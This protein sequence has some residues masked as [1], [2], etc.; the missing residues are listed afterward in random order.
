MAQQ[1]GNVHRVGVLRVGPTPPSW[2]E[3]FRK[4]LRD[5]GYVE[6][7]NLIIEF[8]LAKTAS[9]LPELSAELIQ[10]KVDVI[11]ASGTPSV[12]PAKHSGIPVV[13]VA[14]VDPVAAGVAASLAKPGGNVTG[15]SA[16]HADVTGKRLQL[17]K[18]LI[19]KI[20]KIA[21]LVRATSP[22]APQYV[23]E[24][25]DAAGILSVE[26]QVLGVRDPSQFEVAFGS[27]QA[28]GALIVSDDAVFTAER[29]RIAELAVKNRLPTIYGFGDMVEA[30]GLMAYGPHY[31]DLYRRAAT[32]VH[33]ILTGTKPADIAIE[34]PTKFEMV[35]N[36]KTAKALGLE[37]PPAFLAR[38]DQV[39]E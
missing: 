12:M 22:A 25:Q 14:A 4:G 1:T 24:A 2:I 9:Q 5:L 10:R 31:G 6:G 28:A 21:L 33:K 30:G 11:L 29:T 36:L 8:G 26:L 17:L 37:M 3:S 27:A 7:Q 16:V 23:K 18:E 34:E 39:I 38:A 19:P 32:H 15:V 20:S 13:F 35:I